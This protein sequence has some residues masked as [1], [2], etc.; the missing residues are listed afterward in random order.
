[1][2]SLEPTYARL[3]GGF[4]RN[5]KVEKVSLEAC[6]L[7]VK[8]WSYSADKGTNGKIPLAILKAW[9]GKRFNRLFRELISAGFFSD[10]DQIFDRSLTDS[11]TICH[12]WLD[13]NEIAPSLLRVKETGTKKVYDVVRSADLS[14]VVNRSEEPTTS[15][16]ADS[17]AVV[18]PRIDEHGVIPTDVADDG[19]EAVRAPISAANESTLKSQ[20]TTTLPSKKATA[21]H[22]QII[23]IFCHWQRVMKHERSHLDAKRRTRIG[24]ALKLGYSEAECIQAI[25]GC[26]ASAWHMGAND[27]NMRYDSIDVIFRSADQI[28]KFLTL[29]LEGAPRVETPAAPPLMLV[30]E[31]SDEAIERTRQRLALQRQQAANGRAR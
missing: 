9:A 28:D 8:A 7:L 5:E 27:R 10:S 25:D 23:A 18:R 19:K 3:M 26:R 14:V 13:H 24:S 30:G 20:E 31:P 29:A 21:N 16:D 6:G 17:S 1:M 2:T 15:V 11:F 12:D 22:D 4:W